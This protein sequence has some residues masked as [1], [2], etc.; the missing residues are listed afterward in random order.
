MFLLVN[1]LNFSNNLFTLSTF[2]LIILNQFGNL[3]YK[4]YNDFI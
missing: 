2:N 3:K 4:R 1:L